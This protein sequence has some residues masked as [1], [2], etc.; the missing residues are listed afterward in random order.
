MLG[1]IALG[2]AKDTRTAISLSSVNIERMKDF[3][4]ARG[5]A[6]YALRRMSTA[7]DAS[8][9]GP[10][11]GHQQDEEGEESSITSEEPPADGE[12][13]PISGDNIDEDNMS[14]DEEQKEAV[15]WTPGRDPYSVQIGSAS[16]SVYLSDENGK[17]NINAISDEDRDFYKDF[18]IQKGIDM[19][20]ADEIVD[21]IL[22]W[23]DPDDLTHLNGAEDN[24]YG[25][26][27]EPYKTKNDTFDSIEELTLIKGITP[28]I[29]EVIRND[30]TVYG[31]EQ[32][33]INVSFASKETLSSILGLTDEIIDDLMLYIDENGPIEDNAEMR[34]LFWDLGIVGDSF[35]DI[36]SI[37]TLE[38][39]N[40]VTILSICSD[41][42]TTAYGPENSDDENVQSV[43]GG[44]EYKL[45]AGKEDNKYVILT[46]YPE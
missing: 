12:A 4:A 32:I 14:Q 24:Y 40:F 9:I 26:L 41:S 29:F 2:F 30:V 5:A 28:E 33:A 15:K 27:P 22:D 38:Q 31:G 36:K 37:T 19:L 10:M 35:E 43:S 17:T 34:D 3:Y 44:Y 13:A 18:F 1:M 7:G 21:S 16:C 20:D 8:A 23:I 46:V 39:S 11:S 42:G 45:I 6:V 25:S